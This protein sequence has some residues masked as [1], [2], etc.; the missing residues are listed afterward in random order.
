MRASLLSSNGHRS[1]LFPYLTFCILFCLKCV[2]HKELESQW[3]RY[4]NQIRELRN[5]PGHAVSY[6]KLPRACFALSEQR[7]LPSDSP[8]LSCA[9]NSETLD[10]YFFLCLSSL[11]FKKKK[12]SV[13]PVWSSCCLQNLIHCSSMMNYIQV[14]WSPQ[15]TGKQKWMWV[16]RGG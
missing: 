5:E 9:S 12:K 14:N 1:I 7:S 13:W 15:D 16:W 10:N 6:V 11:K 8:G 3:L 4:S 2:A